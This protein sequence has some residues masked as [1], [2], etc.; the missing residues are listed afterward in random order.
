MRLRNKE[1]NRRKARRR[2]TKE[3]K[4]RIVATSDSKLK[5]KLME[6]LLRINPYLQH[7]K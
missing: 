3:L 2:K 5:S 7:S 6:K 1:I 4:N